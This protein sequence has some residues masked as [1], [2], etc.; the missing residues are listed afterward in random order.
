MSREAD[1]YQ[2][3]LARYRAAIAR[4]PKAA[5]QRYGM[6][7][8][9]SIDPAERALALKQWGTEIGE[10]VDYYNLGVKFAQDDNWSEAILYFK[11]AV[12]QDPELTE[13]IYNLAICYEKTGHTPQAR[14]T[15]EV[16]L[17]TLERES[18]E[19]DRV[20]QHLKGLE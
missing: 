16:Y 2:R 6:T 11:R 18:A 19:A 8:I 3:E 12:E 9:N 20:R 15:W 17:G 4:D 5:L 7:L 1:L 14:S 10:P 13:A